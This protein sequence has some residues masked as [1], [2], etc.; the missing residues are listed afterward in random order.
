M[1]LIAAAA[2]VV[3]VALAG[4]K[5]SNGEKAEEAE[6]RPLKPVA[7]SACVVHMRYDY[8]GCYGNTPLPVMTDSVN[9][10]AVSVRGT[11]ESADEN[12]VVLNSADA[13][14]KPRQLWVPR[15]A[16]LLIEVQPNK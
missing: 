11:F 9:G 16:V 7:G 3:L 10:A 5:P 13:A 6:K 1:K 4:C 2:V 14:G 8:L 15:E 12:W